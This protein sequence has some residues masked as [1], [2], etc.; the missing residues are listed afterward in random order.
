MRYK[1]M[2]VLS[3]EGMH[4]NMCVARIK[5][6]FDAAGIEAAISLEDK[7]VTVAEGDAARAAEE[8]S[9]LGFDAAER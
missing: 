3:V 8:L 4:C 2:K 1:G 7:T 6:A 9:D 5:K